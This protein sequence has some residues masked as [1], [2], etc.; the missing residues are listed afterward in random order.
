MGSETT[1]LP[2]TGK[3]TPLELGM[4]IHCGLKSIS[5][6]PMEGVRKEALMKIRAYHELLGRMI[7]AVE[8]L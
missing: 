3:Y 5:D 2:H 8:Q 1:V 4:M 6:E 7:A